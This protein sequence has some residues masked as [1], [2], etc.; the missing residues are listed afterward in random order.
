MKTAISIFDARI[1]PVFDTAR[2]ICLVERS[3]SGAPTKTFCRFD[4]GDLQA[5]VA[6]LVACGVQ[7]LICGAVSQPLQ[8]ALAAA[9]IDVVSFVCGELDDVIAA[10]A[11]NTLSKPAFAMPGCCGRRRG[12]G[13]QRGYSNFSPANLTT[14]RRH[15]MPRGDGTGPKGMGPKTGRAAGSCAG[16]AEPGSAKG[17]LGKGAGRGLGAG[18]GRGLGLGAG[19]GPDAGTGRGRGRGR[20]TGSGG[21]NA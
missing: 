17:G 16:P 14:E 1:A 9:G 5:K 6:W 12:C 20:A 8:H 21:G 19:R 18:A 3:A 11:A 4:D 7:T 13:A 10:Q 15:T 2:E